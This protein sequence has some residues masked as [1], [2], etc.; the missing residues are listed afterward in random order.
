MN[1]KERQENLCSD[2]A[3]TW[4]MNDGIERC[5]EITPKYRRVYQRRLRVRLT[6]HQWSYCC[7]VHPSM[8]HIIRCYHGTYIVVND[9]HL[10][11]L[12]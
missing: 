1:A 10:K 5:H 8:R 2:C 3:T 6:G 9:V 7:L 4:G 11:E 12:C